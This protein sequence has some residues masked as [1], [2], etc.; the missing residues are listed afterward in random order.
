M[1]AFERVKE[2]DGKGAFQTP[3]YGMSPTTARVCPRRRTRSSLGRPFDH[4]SRIRPEKWK[5]SGLIR[6]LWLSMGGVKNTS[7]PHRKAGARGDSISLERCPIGGVSRRHP[8]TRGSL[9][10]SQVC[11]SQTHKHIMGHRSCKSRSRGYAFPG[12]CWELP[13]VS[14]SVL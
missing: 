7:S 2:T 11:A 13:G 1:A 14:D 8:G 5:I 9:Y 4:N 10:L 6:T 12:S 3:P